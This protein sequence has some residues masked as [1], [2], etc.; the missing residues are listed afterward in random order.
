VQKN[1]ESAL[2]ATATKEDIQ[3]KV[4]KAKVPNMQQ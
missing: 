2:A 4:D 3:I 1:T